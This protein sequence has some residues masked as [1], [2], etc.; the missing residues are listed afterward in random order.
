[1]TRT[2]RWALATL[3]MATAPAFASPAS[4]TPPSAPPE[5][6][7]AAPPGTALQFFA[8]TGDQPV[9]DAMAV[10]ET[11]LDKDNVRHRTLVMFGKKDGKF[12][13]DFLSDKVIACSKCSQFHDDPWDDNFLKFTPGHLHIEQM[14]GGEKV[15]TTF[16]DFVRKAGVWHVTKA[17]RETVFAGYGARTNK[18]LPLPTT[19]L[20]K[21]MDAQWNVPVFLNTILINHSKGDRFTFLHGDATVDAMWKSEEGHCNRQDCTIL[22]QQQDGCLSLV[23]DSNG[24]SFGAGTPD[25]KDEEAATA[26]AMNACTSVGGQ[27]CKEV[28]NDC[29]RGLL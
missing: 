20:A 9:A 7:A 6:M 13:P 2:L 18:K 5:V 25:P 12:V 29:S 1:M 8:S 14:D 24:R 17:R 23:R 3:L 10:F 16:L 26:K 28:R 27:M 22:V 21:D 15:S 19:G 11:P 4:K